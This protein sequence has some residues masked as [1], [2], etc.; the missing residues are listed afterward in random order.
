MA[1]YHAFIDESE[2]QHEK[3]IALGAVLIPEEALPLIE[4]DIRQIR[5]TLAREMRAAGFTA[6]AGTPEEL[7]REKLTIEA[8]RL[9]AGDLPEIH[10]REMWQSEGSYHHERTPEGPDRRNAWLDQIV[11]VIEKY[12]LIYVSRHYE[13][14]RWD[15][16]GPSYEEDLP[17][18]LYTIATPDVSRDKIGLMFDDKYFK[19]TFELFLLLDRL[20]AH[21]IELLSVTCDKGKRTELFGKFE[22]FARAREY[23]HWQNFPDPIFLDSVESNSLQICDFITYFLYKCFYYRGDKKDTK[24]FEIASRLFRFHKEFQTSLPNAIEARHQLEGAFYDLYL[25]MFVEAAL[26]HCGGLKKTVEFRR[27]RADILTR[28][29]LARQIPQALDALGIMAEASIASYEGPV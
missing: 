19:A 22:G 2:F 27:S 23:G 25:S 18:F 1:R 26:L 21:D 5:E 16:E 10:T 29:I 7:K 24:E 28:G 4:A 8:A 14:K 6:Y 20:K 9:R 17:D 13:G 12:D 11:K 3:L 15:N